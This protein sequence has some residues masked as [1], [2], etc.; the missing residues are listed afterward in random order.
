MP[1]PLNTPRPSRLL[2]TLER[3]NLF[4]VP[5]DEERQWYRYHHLFADVLHSALPRRASR[6]GVRAA[7]AG[8]CIVREQND[9]PADAIRHALAGEDFARAADLIERVWL[10]MDV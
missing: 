10:A 6:S 8:Q 1:S 4:V 2:E 3:G 9:P 7:S 5:L